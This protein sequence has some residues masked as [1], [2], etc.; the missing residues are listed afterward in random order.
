[1]SGAFVAHVWQSTLFVLV[2]KALTVALRKDR[3]NVR[4]WLWF[5]ASVKFLV[6]FSL[7]INLG[8]HLTPAP[9]VSRIAPQLA[10]MVLTGTTLP[11]S[12]FSSLGSGARQAS[13]DWTRI[14]LFGLWLCGAV[15]IGFRRIQAWRH[16]RAIV[17]EST[18]SEIPGVS[19]QAG[20]R[21]RSSISLLE[22]SVVGVF[23]PVLLLPSGI[24]E[25]LAPE[26]LHAVLA[27]ELWH[28]AARRV[29]P[30]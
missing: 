6:P 21:I 29:M 13:F 15:A 10:A 23:H 4:Y 9:M 8:T 14:T 16:I 12:A 7:L 25:Y 30:H 3:A 11:V 26:Q 19:A 17:N 24:E 28:N 18:A 1:M 2:V 22:P 27:H 20:V 5:A